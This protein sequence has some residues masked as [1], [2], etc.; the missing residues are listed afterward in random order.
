MR[1]LGS[2]E[3]VR[4]ES[5]TTVENIVNAYFFKGKSLKW[6]GGM[7]EFCCS[8]ELLLNNPEMRK[9]EIL[10]IINKYGKDH[11]SEL[12]EE[13]KRRRLL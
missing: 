6:V 12:I 8:S 7:L 13:M 2:D 4:G 3:Y 9:K 1:N 10:R 5:E 11:K